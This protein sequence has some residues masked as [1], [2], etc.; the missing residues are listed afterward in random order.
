MIDSDLRPA[1][2]CQPYRADHRQ[3]PPL[4][5]C[6]TPPSHM[7]SIQQH[8]EGQNARNILKDHIGILA[9][10]Q[11]KLESLWLELLPA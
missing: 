2:A 1:S 4:G 9:V 5:S 3:L 10:W 8:L 7:S 11:L 6:R